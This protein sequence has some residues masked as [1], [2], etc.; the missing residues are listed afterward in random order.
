[1]TVHFLVGWQMRDGTGEPLFDR[2][3]RQYPSDRR[4]VTYW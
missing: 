3:S 1:M 4:M 2:P